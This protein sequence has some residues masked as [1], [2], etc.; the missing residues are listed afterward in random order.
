MKRFLALLLTLTLA[1]SFVCLAQAEEKEKVRLAVCITM[2]PCE[3]RGLIQD[4]MNRILEEKGIN[5]EVELVFVEFT[6]WGTQ[7]NL[8]LSDGSIDLLNCCFMDPISVLAENGAIAPL[9]DLLAEYGQG[10]V[11]TLGEYLECGKVGGVIYGTPK[12]NA[13]SSQQLFI[14]TTD[15]AEAAQVDL[16]QVHDLTTLTEAL[17]QIHAVFPEK[18]MISC[19]PGGQY[20][21][22]ANLDYLNNTYPYAC[23]KLEKGSDDLTVLN[24]YETQDFKD[25]LAQA[26]EWADLGFFRKDAIN[27]QD[28]VY[29]YIHNHEAVSAYSPAPSVEIKDASNVV[30]YSVRLTTVPISDTAWVTTG[31]VAGMIYA[32]PQLSQHKVGA[33]KLLNALYTDA[34]LAN[35]IG[36]GIEGVH[37]VMTDEGNITYAKE[38]QNTLTSGWPSA[39]GNFWPNELIMHPW[40]P[41]AADTY[42]KYRESNTT[43]EISPAMG[44]VFDTSNVAD[45]IAACDNAVAKYLNV[46]MLGIGDVEALHQQM[47]KEL[48]E[49]GVDDIIAEKQ[50]QLNAWAELK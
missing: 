47:L 16:S 15:E 7:M 48:K 13:Y 36:C 50:A 9:D 49:N 43:C 5:V 20:Y 6:A 22:P 42:E 33:M 26:K 41:A 3:D 37:Y 2:N 40:A 32:I 44:F 27:T 10:I 30:T 34:D 1:V 29:N 12:M 39:M 11:D 45:E 24:Y 31:N 46:M 21:D 38:G 23:L 28:A 4:E 25:L 35:V 8:M 18:T 17:K 19:G 14:I